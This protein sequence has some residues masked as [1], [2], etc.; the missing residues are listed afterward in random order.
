MKPV[1]TRTSGHKPWNLRLHKFNYLFVDGDFLQ[2]EAGRSFETLVGTHLQVHKASQPRR[3]F[4][5]LWKL[6]ISPYLLRLQQFACTIWTGGGLLWPRWWN[7]RFLSQLVSYSIGKLHDKLN[8]DRGLY[9]INNG[10]L[11]QA[12]VIFIF[13]HSL[14][15]PASTGFAE[16]P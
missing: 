10:T 16:I 6:Q 1:N 11:S 3:H 12:G 2:T 15:N 8:I 5:P 4:L 7:F 13:G 14:L 9:V